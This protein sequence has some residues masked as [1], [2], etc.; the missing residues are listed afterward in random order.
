MWSKKEADSLSKLFRQFDEQGIHWMVFRNFDGLPDCNPS[1][2]VDL[3]IDRKEIATAREIVEKTMHACGYHYRTFDEFQCI[4]CYSFFDENS[5]SSIKIDLFYGQVWRG[6]PTI[7]FEAIY[8]TASIYNGFKVPNPEMNAFL[9]W[10]KPVMT[11]GQT[12]KK[13]L[14][15]IQ[16][17]VDTPAFHALTQQAFGEKFYKLVN[18]YMTADRIAD[19]GMFQKEMCKRSWLKA[20][21]KNPID[22]LAS[23]VLHFVLEIKR[24][25]RR[26]IGTVICLLG[27]DGVGKTTILE[28]L[29][30]SAV[31]IFIRDDEKVVTRHFRPGVLPNLKKVISGK[32]YD[33]S[34]EKF[35]EPHRAEQAGMLSSFVR[36][37]YYWLDYIIGWPKLKKECVN[38]HIVLYD[39]YIYDFYVDPR[40]SRIKLSDK[41]RMF[42]VKHTPHP[43][44][45]F[46]LIANPTTILARKAE[47]DKD[48]IARQLEEY[49]VLAQQF[50]NV[51]LINAEQM[52]DAIVQE[53]CRQW[54]K[55]L[56][57]N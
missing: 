31:D 8:N 36:M 38:G 14:T 50:K 55:T 45:V 7:S 27:P 11:G 23:T 19:T 29:R 39:R 1:K 44:L 53:I 22:V 2:D 16:K 5:L 40:R 6:S 41:V 43:D 57:P 17:Y 4:W 28:K 32:S 34:S 47:L 56:I 26:P 13:Y 3:L 15:E 51:N 54:I 33:E 48:E 37:T 30:E 49:E 52:P 12:K 25:S 21:K 10:I 46:A 9:L 24:R 42:F 18:P 20:L 35:T